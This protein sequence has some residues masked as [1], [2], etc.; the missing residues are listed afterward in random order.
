MDELDLLKKDWKRSEHGYKQLNEGE[1]Y[2]LLHRKSSSIVKWILII[3]VLELLFWSA[4]AFVGDTGRDKF[5]NEVIMQCIEGFSYFNYVVIAVFIVLFYRN[6]RRI[7]ATSATRE[8]MQD[9]L[10]TRKTVNYYIWY[11]LTV[12]VISLILGFILAF[13][14]MPHGNEIFN[15]GWAT[16]AV[17]GLLLVAIIVL[18]GILWLFYQLIYGVLL[19]RLLANYRELKKMDTDE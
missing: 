13:S 7:S 1:I 4:F 8:L 2:E 15:N 5:K 12:L 6:Y 11:N 14:R 17:I 18:A 19:R 10:R 9:I 16:A 3:S